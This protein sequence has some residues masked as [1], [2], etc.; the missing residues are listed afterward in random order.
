AGASTTSSTRKVAA[1]V[2]RPG[3][4]GAWATTTRG[5][6]HSQ[7]HGAATGPLAAARDERFEAVRAAWREGRSLGDAADWAGA[8]RAV[9]AIRGVRWGAPAA[10]PGGPGPV[11]P[12]SGRP[13]AGQV[14]RRAG[15]LFRKRLSWNKLW[16]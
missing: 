9:N 15:Y 1:P 11:P 5:V 12:A 6:E 8:R 7:P 3:P 2:R 10:N 16:R 4:D 13:G 14:P